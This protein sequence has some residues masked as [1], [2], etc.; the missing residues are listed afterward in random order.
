MRSNHLERILG[1]LDDLG[2]DNLAILVQRLA[3]ER[4]LLEMVFNTIQEGVLVIN[5][6]GV[7]EY[8]NQAA[9]KMMGIEEKELGKAILWKLVPGLARSLNFE[10][11]EQESQ[12]A[13]VSRELE[14]T[15]PEHRYVRLYLVPFFAPDERQRF[16]VILSDITEARSSTEELIENEKIESIFMLAAGVAH[17]LGNP[18]N[19]LNIHLQ[20]MKRELAA[21]QKGKGIEKGKAIENLAESIAVC[22]AETQR[23]DGIIKHFLGAIRHSS[24]DLVELNLV[25]VLDEILAFQAKELENLG[26]QVEVSLNEAFPIV[27]GDKSQLKQVFFNVIKN[28]MESMG[29]GGKLTINMRTD[30]DFAFVTF[31]DTGIGIRQEDLGNIFQPYYSTKASGHGLGMMI[32]QRIMRAHKAHIGVDSQEGK[33]TTVTLQFPLKV[34][35]SRMLQD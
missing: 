32:V 13:V 14:L 8:A 11:Q 12:A 20:L 4:A 19:T 29:R 15:Y 1:H 2:P 5:R 33:G 27:L 24:L 35:K 25:A 31:T 28:A 22:E 9:L 30:G 10:V 23:L 16:T 18:L 6:E 21:I 7:V 3:R 34:K 26:I 17:E